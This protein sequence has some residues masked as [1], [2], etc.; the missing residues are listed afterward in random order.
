MKFINTAFENAS[1]LDWEVDS[2][3]VINLSL[4]YDHERSSPNRTVNHWYFQIQAEPGSDLTLILKN[5]DNIWNGQR[6]YPV[7]DKTSCLISEDGIKWTAIPT[8]LINENHLKFQVHMKSDKLYLASVEP[9][10]LS[11]LEKLKTEI[12]QNPLVEISTI[13]KTVEG[14]PLEIIRVGHPDAP[15]EFSSELV[16]MHGNLAETG[17]CKA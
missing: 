6:A 14:R 11:D 13:G 12:N 15:I 16:P 1:Q 2:V 17:W 3:G 9:Y 7:S 10:T 5:F 8:E 4:I